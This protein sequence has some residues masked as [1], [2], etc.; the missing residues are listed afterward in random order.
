MGI[1]SYNL[2]EASAITQGIDLAANKMGVALVPQSA[3]RFRHP[4]V[5]FKPLT[6]RLLRI[7]TAMF[8]RRDRMQGDVRE[9][10]DSA[11]IALR[12]L[13]TEL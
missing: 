4:G 6:D 2:Q 12:P 13:K 3:A 10:V 1:H 8:V 7:E 11:L 5:L 9:F